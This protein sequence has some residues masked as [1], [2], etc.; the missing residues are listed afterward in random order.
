MGYAPGST[1]RLS[2]MPLRR[3]CGEFRDDPVAV[4][5][6]RLLL[7]VRHQVDVELV[8]ADLLELTQLLLA[9]VDAADHAEA[10]TDLVGHEFAVLRADARML[11][12]VVELAGEHVLGERL[13]D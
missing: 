5:L 6:E 8:D 7:A 2:L 3:D 4:G 10:V 9:L 1:L 12:V 11:V 13:R